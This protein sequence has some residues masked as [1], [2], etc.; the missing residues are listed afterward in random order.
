MPKPM[1]YKDEKGNVLYGFSQT[2]LDRTNAKLNDMVFAMKVLI[3]LFAIL[4]IAVA[5]FIG[6]L[7]YHDVIT[8]IIYKY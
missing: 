1:E 7:S 8:R 4:L 6:W 2:S 3:L 5:L